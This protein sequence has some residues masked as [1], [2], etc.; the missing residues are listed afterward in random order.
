MRVR[1]FTTVGKPLE[2]MKESGIPYEIFFLDASDD[3]IVKRFKETRRAHPLAMDGR[4]EDGIAREREQI[5]YLKKNATY[6]LDTS[7]MLIRDL[8][9]EINDIYASNKDYGNLYLNILSFGFKYGIPADAD[10]VFDVR[11]L[12]NPYYIDELKSE[13]GRDKSVHDYVMSFE[14]SHV[15]LEKLEGY[16]GLSDT[17]LCQGG[18]EPAGDSN[19]L[20]RWQ[21]PLGVSGGRDICHAQ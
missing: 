17:Q 4:I 11:F 20:Y 15:F 13:T 12:P 8:K 1:D 2:A 18:K 16:A 14:E 9:K 3:V 10:L 21:A 7:H 5:A 19:R 6:I